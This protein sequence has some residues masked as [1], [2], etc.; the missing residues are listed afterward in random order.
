MRGQSIPTPGD[1]S[2]VT[3]FLACCFIV[4]LV[5]WVFILLLPAQ[6]MRLSVWLRNHSNGLAA[7]YREYRAAFKGY[8]LANSKGKR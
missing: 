5:Y 7:A 6:S 3:S 2:L 4:W 8:E 1:G